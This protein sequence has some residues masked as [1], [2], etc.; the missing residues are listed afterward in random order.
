[1]SNDN[2][3]RIFLEL[4][5]SAKEVGLLTSVAHLYSPYLAQLFT[6]RYVEKVGCVV[7]NFVMYEM[8]RPCLSEG[9]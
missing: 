1:M 8:L 9:T 4:Y 2:Q 7:S 6:L 3:C 5:C